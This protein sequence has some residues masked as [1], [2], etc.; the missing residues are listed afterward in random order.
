MTS[1]G[2][3]TKDMPN[4]GYLWTQDHNYQLSEQNGGNGLFK[5]TLKVETDTTFAFMPISVLGS[6]A[7]VVPVEIGLE[8]QIRLYGTGF[9]SK[10]AARRR[11]GPG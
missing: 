10:N 7:P 11:S 8:F 4:G 1:G 9:R 5:A 2:A 3:G 6:P